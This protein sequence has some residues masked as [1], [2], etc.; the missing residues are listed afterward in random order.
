MGGEGLGVLRP[1]TWGLHLGSAVRM[2]GCGVRVGGRGELRQRTHLLFVVVRVDFCFSCS[3][4]DPS[5]VG[6]G[7]HRAAQNSGFSR[8]VSHQPSLEKRSP[9]DVW[10]ERC[11]GLPTSGARAL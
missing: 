4:L 7:R 6:R 8:S 2:K 9:P 5:P 3:I 1:Q 10:P 11:E